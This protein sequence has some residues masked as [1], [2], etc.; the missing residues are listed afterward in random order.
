MPIPDAGV[1]D[2][3]PSVP[4]A[5]IGMT[6]PD[7]RLD[8]TVVVDSD[9]GDGYCHQV[10]VLNT[11]METVDWSIPL[12]LEGTLSEGSPWNAMADARSGRVNFT[13]VTWNR[14]LDP[15]ASADFGFCASR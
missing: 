10:T 5:D 15:A 8:V 14:R 11:S 2:A 3:T 12:D 6:G 9:W 4:D 13:G 1:P 7:P